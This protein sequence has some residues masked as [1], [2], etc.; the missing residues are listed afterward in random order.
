[1]KEDLKVVSLSP[2][3][4]ECEQPLPQFLEGVQAGWPSPAADYVE[5]S[6]DLNELIVKHPAATFYIRVEGDSMRDAGIL[7]GDI[8]VVDRSLEPSN[9]K[10]VVAVINGEFTVKR[11]VLTQ[12]G[13]ILGSEN[14]AYPSFQVDAETDF[15]VWGVVTYAIHKL[16]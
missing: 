11:I 5:Q 10:I 2:A 7:S 4:V 8:L 9:G 14:R 3:S 16:A 12:N 13:I 6:L 15:Q 1:V